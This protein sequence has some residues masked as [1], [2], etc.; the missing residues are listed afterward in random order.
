VCNVRHAVAN[1]R[2]SYAEML[3]HCSDD[4]KYLT[5]IDTNRISLR[6]C[7]GL[8]AEPPAARIVAGNISKWPAVLASWRPCLIATLPVRPTRLI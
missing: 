3:A 5:Y 7:G 1:P 8:G 4:C 2:I 6:L